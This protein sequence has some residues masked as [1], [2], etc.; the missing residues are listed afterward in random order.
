MAFAR[1]ANFY[2]DIH[3]AGGK[4]FA[5]TFNNALGCLVF[6]AANYAIF[7]ENLADAGF[8]LLGINQMGVF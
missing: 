3:Q 5:V 4:I 7:N 8:T 2:P 6:K 1:L